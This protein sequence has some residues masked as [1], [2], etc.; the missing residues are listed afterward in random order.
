MATNG[1][2]RIRGIRAM[3]TNQNHNTT[4]VRAPYYKQFNK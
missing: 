3:F 4:K 1:M 2:Y